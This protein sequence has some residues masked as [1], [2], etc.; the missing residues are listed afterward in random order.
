[1]L[2]C[3]VSMNL[4]SFCTGV[5]TVL[6]Y[7]ARTTSVS[8]FYGENAI[9]AARVDEWL[10]Y[11]PLILSGSESEAACS[12]L[13]GYLAS[14]TFLVGHGLTVAD[15]V[16][17]SN[18]RGAGQRW[19]SLRRSRKY[20]NLVR[21]FNSVAVDYALEEVTSVYV[22]KR[23]IGKSPAPCL[24]EKMPG[25]KNTSGH[26]ID[27]PGAKVGEVCVRFA[28]EPSGYLHIG[29]AKA[30]LL[31]QYFADRYKGRLLVRFDD[32]NPSKES[33]EFVENVLKDIETLGV[34]YDAVTYTSDYFP[35]LM[36]M[37]E[38]LIKQGKAYVDDTPKDKMNTERR[39]GVESK[40]RNSTVEENLLLWSEMVNGTKRGTQCCVR[41]KLDMQDPNKSLRDPVYYRCNPDPHHRVGSKYKVYP[42]YDFA[43]PFVDALQGVTHALR[44][45][46]YHDRNAQYYR[47]LQ[48]MGLRRVEPYEFS[49]LNMVYT[50]LSKR[51]LRWFVQNKKVEDWTDAR[52]P[53]I[54]GV[55][56][57]GL[58]VEALIQFILEQGASKNLNLMEWDKL[59]TINKKII[60]PACGR[61]T[62][63]LKDKSVPLTLTN[64][65]AVPFIRILPRHKKCEGAGNKAITFANR[66]WLEYA[67]ASAITV[68]EEVTLMDWGNA[69]IKEIKIDDGTITQ[70]VGELHPDGSVKM[71][72]LKLT[73]LSDIE[74]LVSLSLVDFD[75]LIINKKLELGEDDKP[76]GEKF[77]ENLNPCTRREALALG[78][79]NMRNIKRGEVV[80]LERKG[81]YRCDVPFV[82]SSKPVML[83]A[84]EVHVDCFWSL[85]STSYVG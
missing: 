69:I 3:S 37:A 59:W 29:H 85:A 63:V 7:I 52:F 71:T 12:F 75:Y 16:V 40:C 82:G 22:G 79:P 46:E 15:I 67:D 30:A 64:G 23:A 2:I 72:K 36:E 6:R 74:D 4:S 60:D 10:E 43:C 45:S 44:S 1:M 17:W 41:G 53:T 19:E 51:T 81:Y 80:Q 31:N 55:L 24:K 54:Q 68:G 25:L 70:L 78:D 26:E 5:N 28:P 73:W 77:L 8:S 61:H 13:D 65:P 66:I 18:L 84:T 35:K 76:G 20:Q 32:T 47:I 49:R 58:K 38:C 39:D 21:W 14:R 27:L 50:V 34:K 42:T 9:Q 57:R 11:A 48:D 62:A 56:R 33:S 83:F